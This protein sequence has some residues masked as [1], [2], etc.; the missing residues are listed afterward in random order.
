MHFNIDFAII[1]IY[2]CSD[3]A[4]CVKHYMGNNQEYDRNSAS[5][6]IPNRAAKE[7]YYQPY[8]SAVDAGR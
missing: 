4:A 1:C 6:N 5:S 7:L 2:F 8:A 3:P